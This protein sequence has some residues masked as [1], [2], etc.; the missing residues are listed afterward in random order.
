MSA[1]KISIV[2]V[3]YNSIDEITKAVESLKSCLQDFEI[4]ISSN[5]M[6]DSDKRVE[7]QQQFCDCRWIFNEKNGGF[8]YAM[9]RG[10]E[11]ASGDYLVISN[12]DC[13]F[14]KGIEQMADFLREH[15]E[16]GAIAPQI[17]DKEGNIQDSVREYVT[18]PRFV[19]RQLK[20]IIFRQE[21]VLDSKIDY[22]VLQTVDWAIGAFI[23][24]SRKAYTLTGGLCEDYF[25]YAEDLDWCTRIRKAG[26]EI[27]Y[28]PDAQI[29]YKGTRSARK[30]SAYMKIFLKSHFIYWRRYGLFGGYPKRHDYGFEEE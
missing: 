10:L 9:N 18:L 8:A 29:V 1:A 27:V 15:P 4:I 26:F 19:A 14:K 13:V 17:I 23:M 22:N 12:P 28:Y 20:R 5:S 25:M 16:I 2:F 7:I 30:S 24:V 21:L 6:Y 3:E 11:V